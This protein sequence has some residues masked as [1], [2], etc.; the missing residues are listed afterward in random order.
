MS[1]IN[2]IKSII[3]VDLDRFVPEPRVGGASTNG[4]YCGAGGEADRA[5]HGRA[6]SR[7]SRDSACPSAASAASR[8]WR[9]AVEFIALGVDARPGVHRGHAPRLPHRRGHDRRPLRL[10]A[11]RTASRRVDELIGKAVPALLG[12]GRSRSQLRDDREDRPE[13]C[14]G[15][16]LC[17]IACH[18]GAHQCI[19]PQRRKRASRASTR[20]SASA[21]TSARS[22]ARSRT[23]STMVEVAKRT[24]ADDVERP[25]G[26]RQN[27]FAPK[28]GLTKKR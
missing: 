16:H 26:A 13:K 5:P 9:D 15:C 18:D 4:G 22:C 23:A 10:P 14:I 27:N 1:L 12:V 21:A 20:A 2:T 8:N 11:T 25:R 19:H 7:A 6:R 3:G 24:P 17:V 28:K